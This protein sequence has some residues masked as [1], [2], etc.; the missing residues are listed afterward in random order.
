[1][2]GR[3]KEVFAVAILF[4]VLTWLSISLR[5]YVRGFMIRT[6][7]N[8]DWVMLATVVNRSHIFPATFDDVLTVLAHLHG[9]P[10]VPNGCGSLWDRPTSERP[11][12]SRCKDCPSSTYRS[13]ITV[14]TA[15]FPSFGISVSYYM[16]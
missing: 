7:G 14:Y 4:L 16:C 6:W 11:Q 5:I 12:Q 8:D 15:K 9:L 10:G 3:G 2:E 1:M 13:L